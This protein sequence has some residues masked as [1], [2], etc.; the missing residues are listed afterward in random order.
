MK[1][2]QYLKIAIFIAV[3]IPG[4]SYCQDLAYKSDGN[5]LNINIISI[6]DGTIIYNLPGN[7][8]GK[9]FYLSTTLIDSLKYRDGRSMVF[10]HEDLKP[11]M[12][13]RNYIGIDLVETFLTWLGDFHLG[14]NNLHI[15]YEHIFKSG[16]TGF[17]IEF[18]QSLNSSDPYYY[19]PDAWEGHW[20]FW[21]GMYLSYDPFK[22]FAKVG[23]NTYPFNYSLTKTGRIRFCTGGSLLLGNIYKYN[24]DDYNWPYEIVREAFIAGLVWNIDAKI[25]LSDALQIKIG[26]DASVIP[27]LV[28]CSPELG[29]TLGF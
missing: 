26:L 21:E 19:W 28:F 4:T 15:S 3:F 20:F 29:I 9:R 16:K 13:K 5:V 17:T 8:S 18:L 2:I 25:Y 7:T 11:A 23:V 22:F 6:K 27:L 12:V 14:P 10:T 24:H 1:Y